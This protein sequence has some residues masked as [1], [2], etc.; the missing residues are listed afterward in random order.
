MLQVGNLKIG[1]RSI[2][3]VN[4][5]AFGD[6]LLGKLIGPITLVVVDLRKCSPETGVAGL[7]LSIVEK[8]LKL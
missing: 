4:L 5:M 7:V 3:R 8:P 1:D 6:H 2:A